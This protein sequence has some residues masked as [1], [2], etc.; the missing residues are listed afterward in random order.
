MIATIPSKIELHQVSAPASKSYAQRAIFAAAMGH[1][2]CLIQN[3]GS[4]EDVKHI[5]DIA[6]ELGAEVSVSE[7]G[8]LIHP[9]KNKVNRSLNCGESGLGIR[10]TTSIASTFGGSFKINGEGSLKT[11]P[12]DSFSTFLPQ[13]GIEFESN[14]GFIP[15]RINGELQ[16]GNIEIDGSMSSQFLSGLLMA[17]PLAQSDSTVQVK[18]LVSVGYLNMTMKVM[19]DFGIEVIENPGHQ[20]SIPGKQVYLNPDNYLVEGDWSGA[21]FWIVLGAIQGPIEIQ[22]L[23]KNS[24][25]ADRAILDVLELCNGEYHWTNNHLSVS[26]SSLKAFKFDATNCPDL[27]P[28]LATLAASIEGQSEIIGIHRLKNKES[29]RALTIQKEFSK[30]GLIIDLEGD[31]M[32]IHG[33][34]NLNSAKTHA[35]HDH[36]IAMACAIASSLTPKGLSIENA[37]AVS[38]SYPEFWSLIDNAELSD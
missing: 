9:R 25:Q 23:N 19:Q 11:R 18:N 32:I 13:L 20:F 7:E 14:N 28:I 17:L 29:N 38:K 15:L 2:A 27:F 1:S 3:L 33:H 30:L 5:L 16:G 36:R 12:M 37:E 10:L 26:K 24:L 4:S 35:N 34:K 6:K 8:T 21:A 31:T 22:G